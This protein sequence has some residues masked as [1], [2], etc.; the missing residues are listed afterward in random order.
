[1]KLVS[2]FDFSC[3]IILFCVLSLMPADLEYGTVT[4]LWAEANIPELTNFELHLPV[5]S[6]IGELKGWIRE[7]TVRAFH[8][9]EF[10]CLPP[11]S[12]LNILGLDPRP[13]ALPHICSTVALNLPG[14]VRSCLHFAVLC[15]SPIPRSTYSSYPAG[16]ERFSADH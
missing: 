15:N 9:L 3:G 2:V 14:S 10:T 12:R 7:K 16:S 1:M 5:L 8:F 13:P 6:T 4:V 11:H